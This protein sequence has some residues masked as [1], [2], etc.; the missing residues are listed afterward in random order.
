MRLWTIHPR[1][2]DAKGLVALWREALLAQAVIRGLTKGY[3]HHPQLDRFYNHESPQSAINA[4]LF[5]VHAES[6][7]RGYNFDQSK[8]EPISTTTQLIYA[9][10]GQLDYEWQHLLAKLKVRS[11]E[12]YQAWIKLERPETQPLFQLK[13]GAIADWENVYM[14]T[15]KEK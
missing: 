12:T 3:K 14:P 13:A 7:Q 11:P 8:F 10:T 6:V 5:H 4:Y 9:T 1:Y 15:F 2:L